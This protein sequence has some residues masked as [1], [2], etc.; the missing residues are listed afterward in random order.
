MLPDPAD[1]PPPR[2]P[3]R[4]AFEGLAVNEFTGAV[5]SCDDVAE[6]GV[7]VETGE[8]V[9]DRLSFDMSVPRVFMCLGIFFALEHLAAY[10]ILSLNAKKYMA[11]EAAKSA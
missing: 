9:L 7:C 10:T 4:Y 3:R 5:F 6:G 1:L 8:E 11:I 2:A